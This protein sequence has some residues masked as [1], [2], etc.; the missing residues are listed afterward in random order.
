MQSQSEGACRS[1]G[2]RLGRISFVSAGGNQSVVESLREHYQVKVIERRTEA[3]R[4]VSEDTGCLV[5]D[6][7]TF[8]AIDNGTVSLSC[9]PIVVFSAVTDPKLAQAVARDDRCDIVYRDA[10]GVASP[11]SASERDR[12]RERIDTAYAESEPRE[13]ENLRDTVLE[14][15]GLLMSAAPDEVDT[16]IEWG[17]GSIAEV[18]GAERSVVYEH[19]GDRLVRT[20]EW[21]AT[22]LDPIEHETTRTA[23]FPG[24]EG[25]LSQ[26][27]LFWADGELRSSS[28]SV[29]ESLSR[30]GY[31]QAESFV[32]VPIVVDWTLQRVLVI[33][34]IQLQKR[35][36]AIESHLQTASELIG[37]TF[38]RNRRHREIERQNERLERFASVISHDLKNPLNV[39]TGYTDLARESGDTEHIDR[40]EAA[41]QRMEDILDDLRT[42]TREARD[43]G[44]RERVAV[45]EVAERASRAVDTKDMAIGIE[46]I[47]TVEADPS[48]LQQAFENLF[49]NSVEHAGSG[50]TVRVEPTEEGFSVVDDG[51][52]FAPEDRERLFVE[53]YTGDDGTGLG[54]GIVR[55]VIEAHGWTIDATDADTGGARFEIAGVRFDEERPKEIK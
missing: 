6:A 1:A 4:S 25:S 17:I 44:E 33:D 40:I 42:L 28:E 30:L 45:S 13:E 54:L 16:K 32:A 41:A 22:G 18:L 8:R 48:R 55:T 43:L 7:E 9:V 39:I 2:Q 14:T 21:Q 19:D 10:T 5:V 36:D 49:R 20:H 3:L 34:G 35:S 38:R 24:F 37:Q 26:F 27:E 52:G 23:T 12:L 31:G 11:E 29:N 50:V 51:T 47:G 46:E 15:A 53:G